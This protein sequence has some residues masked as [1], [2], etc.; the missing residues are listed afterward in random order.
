MNRAPGGRVYFF[1]ESNELF[2]PGGLAVVVG[3]SGGIGQALLGR[4]AEHCRFARVLGLGRGSL[5]PLDLTLEE[6]IAGAA[7]HIRALELDLRLVIDATGFLHADGIVPEKS[8]RDL[9][10]EHMA[11]AFAINAIGPALLMKHFLP[12][13]PRTGKSVLAT[14]SARVGSIGDNRLGGWYKLPGFQGR[15]QPD[16]PNGSTGTHALEAPRHM[17]GAASWNGRDTPVGSVCKGRPRHSDTP[18]GSGQIAGGHRPA[19]L[20]YQRRLLR[21]KWGS[22]TLVMQGFFRSLAAFADPE[23]YE[24][25]ETRGIKYSIRLPA[26]RILQDR[27]GYLLKRPVERPP[28]RVRW[29]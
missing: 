22:R 5:P 20:S 17:R 3:A 1:M 28:H 27:I 8:W 13:L 18:G 21:P 23:V 26:N 29:H 7:R 4:L 6:S 24:Y 2:P 25:V 16:C 9:E 14:L 19:Q 11:Q 15:P 10:A 12:L